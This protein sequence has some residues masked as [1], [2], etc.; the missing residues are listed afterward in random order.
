MMIG[1]TQWCLPDSGINSPALAAQMGF[2][3]I[4]LEI[5]TW[6]KGCPLLDKH[7]QTYMLSQSRKHGLCILPLALN[8]LGGHPMTQGFHSVEGKAARD[9]LKAGLDTASV[10][11]LEGITV[12]SFGENRIVTPEH[13]VH[14]VEALQFACAYAQ[15]LGL[16]VYTENVL[17]AQEMKQL[18]SDCGSDALYLLF[19][20]QNYYHAGKNCTVDVLETFADR[21]GSHVHVKAGGPDQSTCL[22]EG[23]GPFEEVMATLRDMR[24]EGVIVTENQYQKP[25]MGHADM[26]VGEWIRQDQQTIRSRMA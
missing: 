22:G 15:P 17:S 7:W 26:T 12:P 4:Q 10:M 6:E 5:G 23:E 11:G 2:G 24:F 16:R 21:I 8:A 25:A 3:A 13:Y 9:I 18:F 14:T 1:V 19:D 20:S